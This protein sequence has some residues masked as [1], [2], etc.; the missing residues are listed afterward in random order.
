M[1]EVPGNTTNAVATQERLDLAIKTPNKCLNELEHC[2][3]SLFGQGKES[4]AH[5][6][7]RNKANGSRTRLR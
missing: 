4:G 2:M 3:Q 5:R 6:T 1:L 7:G